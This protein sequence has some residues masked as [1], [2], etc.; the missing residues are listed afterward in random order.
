LETAVKKDNWPTPRANE[1]NRT[2]EGY[3]RGLKE[4]V[5]GREQVKRNWPTPTSRDHKDTGDSVANGTV[6]VNGLLGRAV[7]PT[8]MQ[9]SLNP[10]FVE[11]L[12]GYAIGWTV[13]KPLE[14]R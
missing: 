1:P 13:L 6:P 10:A 9:G 2:S 11:Y 3:G 8:K 7:A 5:E 14:I 4:L 12:M